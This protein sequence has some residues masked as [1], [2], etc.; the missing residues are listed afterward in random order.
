M[1]DAG[2]CRWCP[3]GQ[4][5]HKRGRGGCR[6][7][8]CACGQYQADPAAPAVVPAA[9]VVEADPASPVPGVADV[10]P[11]DADPGVQVAGV[12]PAQPGD[13]DLPVLRAT[14][15]TLAEVLAEPEPVGEPE[16]APPVVVASPAAQAAHARQVA[17]TDAQLAVDDDPTPPAPAADVDPEPAAEPEPTIV[18]TQA[19]AARLHAELEQRRADEEQ[20]RQLTAERDR[21]ASRL[22]II[23]QERRREHLAHQVMTLT[24]E[25]DEARGRVVEL[26]EHVGR[27]LDHMGPGDPDRAL[28]RYDA[29][30]C[31]ACGFRTTVPGLRHEHPLIPVTVLVVRR[32]VP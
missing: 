31:E 28:V 13:V 29:D 16:P 14:H 19:E 3:H 15:P 27:L 11:D 23:R 1:P 20:I 5:S 12:E 18:L 25:R 7:L 17:A 4:W 21:L 30:Q 2:L 6:E 10:R 32:E 9:G 24:A 8:D 26:E 22:D